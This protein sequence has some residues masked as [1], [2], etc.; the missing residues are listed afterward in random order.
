MRIL[1]SMA[2]FFQTLCR[3]YQSLH[4]ILEVMSVGKLKPHLLVIIGSLGSKQ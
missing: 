3:N 4:A 1:S 2:I